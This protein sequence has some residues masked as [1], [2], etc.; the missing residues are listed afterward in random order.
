MGKASSQV[1]LNGKLIGQNGVPG[2]TKEIEKVG[3][4]DQV[5]YLPRALLKDTDNHLTFHL[6]SHHGMIQLQNPLHFFGIGPYGD[7][8]QF[9]QRFI[10]LGLGLLGVFI[11]S[12]FYFGNLWLRMKQVKDA[13]LLFFISVFAAGQ[14]FAELSR[15]LF[16]YSYPIQDVRLVAISVLAASVGLCLLAFISNKFADKYKLHWLYVGVLLTVSTMLIVPSFDAKT[17][18]AIIIPVLLSSGI[19]V[20]NLKRHFSW[21][22]ARYLAVLMGFLIIVIPTFRYFH[23]IMYYLILAILLL[24]LF[25]QH[26]RDYSQERVALEE[27]K[28]LRAKLEFK[29][30]QSRQQKAVQTLNIESAGKIE[31]VPVQDILFC[32]AAGDYV[33]ISTHSRQHLYSGSLKKILQELPT[34]FIRVHRSYAVN[35][36]KVIALKRES[37]SGH[38]QLS[39]ETLIPVS[40]RM[41]PSVKESISA[42]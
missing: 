16:D 18:L 23:E 12:A 3:S 32:K 34:T 9:V 24:F 1:Y 36:D 2:A 7:S 27:E 28:S 13:K 42:H 20:V 19:L 33:E 14:L 39:D 11:L 4:M 35:L 22:S 21:R 10:N 26:A 31:K 41:L 37:D 6:S 25:A 29:L 30:E 40:R 8:K 38:L 15:G 5:F 17:T